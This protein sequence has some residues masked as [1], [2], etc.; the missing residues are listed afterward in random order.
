MQMDADRLLFPDNLL[1]QSYDI[2][3]ILGNALDN[4]IE[5]CRK[6]KGKESDAETFIRLSSFRKG[7]MIFIEITNSFDG[8]VIRKRQSEFPATDKADKEAHGIG[9]AN[10]K[11]AAGKYH[12][13][14]DWSV[15]NK[16]FT[17][18]IMLQNERSW[19]KMDIGSLTAFAGYHLQIKTGDCNVPKENWN[20]Y[21]F[22]FWKYFEEAATAESLNNWEAKGKDISEWSDYAQKGAKSIGDSQITI[23]M[24]ESLQKK[25]EEDSDFASKIMEKVSNWKK[26]YDCA[27]MAIGVANGESYAQAKM[28]LQTGSYLIELDENGDIQNYTVT[29]HSTQISSADN[30]EQ[31]VKKKTD[32]MIHARKTI[33]EITNQENSIQNE[34]ID[35]EPDYIEAMTILCSGLRRV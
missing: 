31:G 26:N 25:M 29:T 22:P 23:L 30:N 10:I 34:R 35:K 27:D 16:V 14:V 15:N 21:D 2:G 18:S 17:L 33:C 5:A 6:L 1:I 11:N 9:L 32:G 8:N 7:K 12:G 19:H 24:P 13:A 3:I 4:A 28:A 20:R